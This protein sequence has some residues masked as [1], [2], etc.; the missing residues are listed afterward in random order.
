MILTEPSKS[1]NQVVHEQKFKDLQSRLCEFV[2]IYV[3]V[4]MELTVRTKIDLDL[5]VI[6]SMI[7]LHNIEMSSLS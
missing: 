3:L 5:I 4:T 1:K 6:R 2:N 7:K